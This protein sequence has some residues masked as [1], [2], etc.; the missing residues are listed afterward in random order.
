MV[1]HDMTLE[2]VTTRPLTAR[3]GAE[4]IG[5]DLSRPLDDATAEK[6]RTSGSTRASC[7]SAGETMAMRHRCASA[8]CLAR[9]SR[10]RPRS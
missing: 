2:K 3:F 6:V 10:Q 1:H 7:F 8:A 4:V 5:V 9:W